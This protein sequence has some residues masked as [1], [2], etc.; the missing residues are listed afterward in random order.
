[1]SIWHEEHPSTKLY[2]AYFGVADPTYYR[3]TYTNLP[4]G[5]FY[6]P[7]PEYPRDPGVIA[8]SATHLQGVYHADD[9]MRL[10]FYRRIQRLPLIDVLGGTIYLYKYSGEPLVR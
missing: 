3:I 2:L 7:S 9:P 8:V 6:G 10:E 4:S 1:M 5:Y